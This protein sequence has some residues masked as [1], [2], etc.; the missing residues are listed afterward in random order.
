MLESKYQAKVIKKYEE[1]GFY[2]IKLI[3]TNKTGIPD[4][5][6]LKPD[7]VVF[8]EVKGAKT[9]LSPVQAYIHKLLTSLGFEVLIDRHN[10]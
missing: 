6:C 4:L 5:I 1:Q 3:K 2:V 8:V 9:A 10:L 7:K